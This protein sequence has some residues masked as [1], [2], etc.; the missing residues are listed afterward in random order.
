MDTTTYTNP[1]ASAS[2]SPKRK[3][4]ILKRETLTNPEWSRLPRAGQRLSGISRSQIY[5]LMA[6]GKVRSRKVGKL[7][8]VHIPSLNALIEG[9]PLSDQSVQDA[10]PD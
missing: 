1:D 3:T 8:F 10:V 9:S 4:P 2:V 6:E 7:R 5:E